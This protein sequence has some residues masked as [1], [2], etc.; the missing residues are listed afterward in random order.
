MYVGSGGITAYLESIDMKYIWKYPLKLTDDM[1]AIGMPMSARIVHVALQGQTPTLWA[2]IDPDAP[3]TERNF[4]VHGT[5]HP[6]K[7]GEYVGTC[8]GTPFVWH[9]YEIKPE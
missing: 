6:I 9:I 7:S 5:G 1:Q 3:I 4:S 8:V 2:E